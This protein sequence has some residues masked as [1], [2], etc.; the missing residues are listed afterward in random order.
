MDL[1]YLSIIFYDRVLSDQLETDRCPNVVDGFGIR[2]HYNNTYVG[3]AAVVPVTVRGLCGVVRLAEESRRWRR[4]AVFPAAFHVDP[5]ERSR[6]LLRANIG[7]RIG[8]G[9][10]NG[11][12]SRLIKSSSLVDWNIT[13]VNH[14]PPN[15]DFHRKMEKRSPISVLHS[16]RTVSNNLTRVNRMWKHVDLALLCVHFENRSRSQSF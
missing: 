13:R 15:R 11:N 9:T 7:R 10:C 8:C 12:D 4:S 16:V 1:V 3:D 5:S 6:H 2:R 14:G